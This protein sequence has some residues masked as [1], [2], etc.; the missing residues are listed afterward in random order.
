MINRI[1]APAFVDVD[2]AVPMIAIGVIGIV[3][4]VVVLV[5]SEP[6][7]AHVLI[8]AVAPGAN[9]VRCKRDP[10]MINRNGHI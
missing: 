9:V 7:T 8:H 5:C 2:V 3:E 10:A 1:V 4:Q 6:A